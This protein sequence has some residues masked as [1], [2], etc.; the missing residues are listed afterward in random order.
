[1]ACPVAMM[2]STG[3]VRLTNDSYLI[4]LS[5]HS[6]VE[7]YFKDGD[8]WTKLTGRGRRMPATAEQVLNH[9]LPAL[10]GV[11]SGITVQV[12]H[13]DLHETAA[14]LLGGLRGKGSP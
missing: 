10:A 8:Q 7:R 6:G 12:E 2:W 9:L 4:T 14:Q 11:K 3:L 5:F 1:M 13:R